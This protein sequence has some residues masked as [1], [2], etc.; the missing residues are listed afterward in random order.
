[1]ASACLKM[2]VEAVWFFFLLSCAVGNCYLCCS[3]FVSQKQLWQ[4]IIIFRLIKRKHRSLKDLCQNVVSSFR[5][6][7][8]NSGQCSLLGFRKLRGYYANSI[9]AT[10]TAEYERRENAEDCCK[11]ATRTKWEAF[12]STST[13]SKILKLYYDKKRKISIGSLQRWGGWHCF[14]F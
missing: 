10:V 4:P 8:Q 6:N 5:I 2:P 13:L 7:S 11:N 1:M 14:E 12:R 3:S 9:C